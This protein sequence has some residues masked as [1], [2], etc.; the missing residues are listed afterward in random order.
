MLNDRDGVRARTREV[1]LQTARRLG[2]I[3]DTGAPDRPAQNPATI[4]LAFLLPAGTNAFI[5]ALHQQI[6]TQAATRPALGVKIERIEGFNPQTVAAHLLALKDQAAGIGLIAQD[7]PLVREAIRT[8]AQ[9][10]PQ[11]LTLAT[12]IQS[13]PRLAY[14]G[15]H[16]RQAG[17][18]AGQLMGC[19]LPANQPAKAALFAGSLAYRGHEEREMGF[20]HILREE[21]PRMQI[22]EL[23]EIM[24]DR[25]RAMTET[26]VLLNQ[27]PDL[28]AI[29]KVGGGGTSGNATELRTRALE[30]HVVF[31]CH[32][33][34]ESNKAF[35]LD[36]TVDG[37]VDAVID[38]NPR[39]EAREASTY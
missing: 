25:Q 4:Q 3:S 1:V 19:L 12:E 7:H 27:H 24:D 30:H 32:E 26:S 33:A 17:R 23:R 21:F 38:Q 22:L 6:E 13:V 5:N 2:Y 10:V 16:N 36:G 29:Y 8:L 35:L 28:A 39:V 20:R 14:A 18:L 37:T 34:T 11:V 31:V 15:I 9:S